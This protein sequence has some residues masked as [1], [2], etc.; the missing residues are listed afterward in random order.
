MF[1][2]SNSWQIRGLRHRRL[3]QQGPSILTLQS[4]GPWWGVGAWNMNICNPFPHPQR[5]PEGLW[6]C[7]FTRNLNYFYELSK[8]RINRNLVWILRNPKLEP[9]GWWCLERSESHHTKLLTSCRSLG[10]REVT[11]VVAVHA[12]AGDDWTWLS[13]SGSL[14][15]IEFTDN[16][17]GGGQA[18]RS[19]RNS[20]IIEASGNWNGPRDTFVAE[21]RNLKRLVKRVFSRSWILYV[22]AH[23]LSM[24]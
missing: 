23:P 1:L 13:Q 12:S 22:C 6:S 14:L 20:R 9:T 7:T 18:V 8:P 17:G 2:W 19:I 11:G 24:G 5:L 15:S 10:G 4:R 21:I 3:E 16:T